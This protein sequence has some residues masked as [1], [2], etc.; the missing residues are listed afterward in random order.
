M[1]EFDLSIYAFLNFAK[2]PDSEAKL[3]AKDFCT[4]PDPYLIIK[5]NFSK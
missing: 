1:F 5:E 2:C 4:N 3:E